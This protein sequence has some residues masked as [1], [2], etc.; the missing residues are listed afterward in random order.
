M[1]CAAKLKE[2]P[3][4]MS[5]WYRC[6]QPVLCLLDSRTVRRSYEEP[7]PTQTERMIVQRYKA[8]IAIHSAIDYALACG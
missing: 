3:L 4:H 8:N 1:D 5:V 2:E 7:E 6:R